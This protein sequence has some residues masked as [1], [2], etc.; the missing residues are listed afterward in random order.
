[1]KY[2]TGC[3]MPSRI[4]LY[5]G[6]PRREKANSFRPRSFPTSA[7]TAMT[8]V[9]AATATA[10]RK[11]SSTV[12]CATSSA[13]LENMKLMP[14]ITADVSAASS[15]RIW[16]FFSFMVSTSFCVTRLSYHRRAGKARDGLGRLA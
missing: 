14:K 6:L 8:S 16:I 15:E 4:S 1:M 11:A 3:T 7:F 10:N 9:M 13:S 5:T 12:G 2:A